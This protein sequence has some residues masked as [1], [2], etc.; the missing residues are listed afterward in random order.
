MKFS[1]HYVLV[2]L[3]TF[4]FTATPHHVIAEDQKSILVTGASTGIGRHL[5]ESLASDGHHV[6]AGARKD[7]DLAELDAIENITAVRLDVTRQD[8]VDAVAALITKKGTGLYGL[9]NNE[10]VGCG[11]EVLDTPIG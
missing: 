6:Y 9:V 8:Q 7:K 4:L 5:A 10:G 3:V 2:L 1:I 11:G